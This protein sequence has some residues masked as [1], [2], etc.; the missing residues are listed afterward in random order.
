[1][2]LILRF[3]KITGTNFLLINDRR[4]ISCHKLQKVNDGLQFS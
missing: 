1:M 3:N 4:E 2:R